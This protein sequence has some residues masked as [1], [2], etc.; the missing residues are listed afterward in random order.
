MTGN[1]LYEPLTGNPA[2]RGTQRWVKSAGLIGVVLAALAGAASLALTDD[3]SRGGEPQAIAAIEHQAPVAIAVVTAPPLPTSPPAVTGSI[4]AAAQPPT[5]GHGAASYSGQS[6]EVQNGVTIYRPIFGA[7]PGM[8]V[9][10]VPQ[11]GADAGP[12]AGGDGPRIVPDVRL[13]EPGPYGPLPRIGPDG[14]RAADV[15]ARSPGPEG[16]PKV[17]LLI[18]GFGFDREATTRAAVDLPG[19]VTIGFTPY[20]T[21]LGGQVRAARASA[22]EIVLQLPMEGFGKND[23]PPLHMLTTDLSKSADN[24]LWLLSRFPGYAGVANLLGGRILTD[25]AVLRPLAQSIANR[26]L[27]FLEDGTT[28]QSHLESVARDTGLPSARADI[29][30]DARSDATTVEQDLARLE[31]LARTRG[32]AIGTMIGRPDLM[33][34]VVRFAAGLPEHGVTL[35]PLSQAMRA[36]RLVGTAGLTVSR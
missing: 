27:Y 1:E 8:A 18:G 9:L 36:K 2:R 26:G 34:A 25:D 7:S 28:P 10:K 5:E 33:Q 35:V 15:Y 31:S 19:A 32:V 12:Y 20:G 16:T 3:G 29:V 23:Q 24:L 11:G 22:H 30:I 13:V 4:V 6:V 21:D 14:A 17:A